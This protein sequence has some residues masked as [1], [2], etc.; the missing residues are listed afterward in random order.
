MGNISHVKKKTQHSIEFIWKLPGNSR[1]HH[2]IYK[3][4]KTKKKKRLSCRIVQFFKTERNP[5]LFNINRSLYLSKGEAWMVKPS[6]SARGPKSW[7]IS[8]ALCNEILCQLL[9]GHQM[10]TDGHKI[11]HI[12]N[13]KRNETI[14]IIMNKICYYFSVSD[15]TQIN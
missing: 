13:R 14:K 1:K 3:Y 11:N 7:H 9:N 2:Q 8:R 4:A 5:S 15:F 12:R 6:Q 10:Q